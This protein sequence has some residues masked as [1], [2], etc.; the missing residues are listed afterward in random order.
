MHLIGSPATP[1]VRRCLTAARSQGPET[2]AEPTPGGVMLSGAF[3]AIGP[4]ARSPVPAPDGGG[5]GGESG[6]IAAWPGEETRRA[7]GII[8]ARPAR[9]ARAETRTVRREERNA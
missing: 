5:Y 1:F 4:M 3:R 2:A 9:P 8:M 6:T 7:F